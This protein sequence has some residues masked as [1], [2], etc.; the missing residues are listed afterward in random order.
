[1]PCR[2]MALTL[3]F[4]S[5]VWLLAITLILSQIV[6]RKSNTLSTSVHHPAAF[7]LVS[8]CF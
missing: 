4:W 3:K 8:K 6:K 5:D 7:R 1:M 2:A